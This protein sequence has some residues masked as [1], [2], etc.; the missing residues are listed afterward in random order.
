MPLALLVTLAGEAQM[1]AIGPESK[2]GAPLAP[3][4]MTAMPE[5][6]YVSATFA[7]AAEP[8][9]LAPASASAIT[10]SPPYKRTRN[11]AEEGLTDRLHPFRE[12]GGA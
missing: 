11:F 3:S 4:G 7:K 10:L 6:L 1:G 8:A 12:F 9:L 5:K 2:D